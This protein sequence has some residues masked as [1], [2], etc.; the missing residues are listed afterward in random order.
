MFNDSDTTVTSKFIAYPTLAYAPETS[1]EIGASTLFIYYANK[2]N[3][4]TYV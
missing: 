2:L 3:K 4:H 1:W